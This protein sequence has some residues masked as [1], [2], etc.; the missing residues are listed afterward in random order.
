MPKSRISAPPVPVSDA[1]EGRASR[2]GRIGKVVIV[3]RDAAL[4]LAVNVL[5][6]A[7]HRTGLEIVAVELPSRLRTGDLFP[8]LQNQQAFHGLMGIKEGPLMAA[9]QATYSLAQRFAGFSGARTAFIHGYGAYGAPIN[10]V[11]FHHY[12]MKARANGLKAGYDDFSLNAV[13]ARQGRFFMPDADTDSF[14]ECDYVYH[15]PAAAYCQVLRQVALQ[16]GIEPVQAGLGAVSR[17]PQSGYITAIG[18]SNGQTVTGDFFIDAT[19][20]QS[21]LLGTALKTEFLSW[22]QWFPCDRLLTTTGPAIRAL[23]ALSEVQAFR[24]GWV[25]L[26]PLRD[27]TAVQQAYASADLDE[28]EALNSA[29]EV[30]AMRF[31]AES[32]VTPYAP[33]RRRSIW[34]ANCVGIGEAAAVFDPIDSVGIQVILAG[35]AHLTSLFPVDAHMGPESAEYNRNVTATFEHIRDYQI[36]HYKLNQRHGEPLWDD[37]RATAAPDSLGYKIDLFEAR[38]HLVE[39][40]EETFVD[41]DWHSLFIGHGLMP[42]AYDPMVDQTPDKDVIQRL[43]Q[44]LAT[45]GRR[46]EAM[47]PMEAYFT[48]PAPVT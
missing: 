19:G 40:D 25:G 20:A 17:D 5:W 35:L 18:L 38:G 2:P 10:T 8:T 41:H 44:I 11:P 27:R 32:V 22:R 46:V 21:L 26:F 30:T 4:W 39:Y 24:S 37:C 42:R 47:K 9:T 45:I 7:F 12:W 15:L 33:G 16:R 29:A 43:R 34:S 1:S 3:G 14:A 36:G 13:A 28:E 23:P 48:R 6:T 31:G